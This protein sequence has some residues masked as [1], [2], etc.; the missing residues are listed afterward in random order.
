LDNAD[1]SPP[2]GQSPEGADH[3]ADDRGHLHPTRGGEEQSV[4][5]PQRKC[6]GKVF[7]RGARSGGK[8]GA[9]SAPPSAAT[10]TVPAATEISEAIPAFSTNQS[11]LAELAGLPMMMLQKWGLTRDETRDEVNRIFAAARHR[12]A[13]L[14]ELFLKME[15]RSYWDVRRKLAWL[16][17]EADKMAKHPMYWPVFKK[18]RCGTGQ[19][20]AVVIDAIGAI[21][22]AGRHATVAKLMEYTGKT[23]PSI[24]AITIS[25]IRAGTIIRLKPGIFALPQEG[26]A[27][28]VR[29]C[30]LILSVL[31]PAPSG[32]ESI[33]KL[34]ADTGLPRHSLN[35]AISNMRQWGVLA[36]LSRRGQVALSAASFAKI[37]RGKVIRDGR[38]S[39][40]W[41]SSVAARQ[42]AA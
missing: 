16:R 27:A 25:G 30:K 31:I 15:G 2:A 18:L 6:G 7:L 36:P 1:G 19:G 26:V 23:R 4:P 40:I 5:H 32:S 37:R 14:T 8:V 13:S 11:S 10:T 21:Q 9:P 3:P 12:A 22:A 28:H 29:P 34:L 38:G 39:I 41:G 35:K 17:A 20:E 33:R 42:G 24:T